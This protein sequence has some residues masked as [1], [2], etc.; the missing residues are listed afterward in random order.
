MY[1][2]EEHRIE[3]EKWI[4]LSICLG[5]LEMIFRSG[6]YFVWNADGYRSNFIIWIGVLTGVLKQGISRCLIVMVSL[7][8]GV[9]RDSLGSTMRTIVVLGA[10]YI[11]V[12]AVRD[13]MLVFAVE[14]MTTLSYDAEEEI[15]SVIRILTLVISA[16][17]VIF[18]MWIL[19]ALNNTMMY[20]ENMNQSRKLERYLKLRCLFLFSILFATM[21]AVFTLVHTVNEEG[22]VEEENAWAIDAASEV[23]YLFVLVGVAYLWRPNP[24]AKEYAYVMELPVM[25]ADGENELELTGAVPSAMDSDDGSDVIVSGKNGYH[26]DKGFHDD[27]DNDGRFQIS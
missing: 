12:S 24:N 7:G 10:S 6:D 13:L 17:D 25:G 14:D 20:L 8:W 23:N 2:N 18:I 26:D 11:G 15:F 4:F 1:V 9:V 3:I 27:E 21:W 16:V 5:L 22:I 19:D